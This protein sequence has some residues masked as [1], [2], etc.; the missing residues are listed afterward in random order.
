MRR[1]RVEMLEESLENV[2]VL[3][4][5]K[6]LKTKKEKALYLFMEGTDDFSYYSNKISLIASVAD[7]DLVKIDCGGKSGVVEACKIIS[8]GKEYSNYR[9]FY[10]VDKDYNE[11]NLKD[12]IYVTPYYSMDS[13]Y[14]FDSV[15]NKIL[16]DDM[17]IDKQYVK[18]IIT[19]YGN[20]KKELLDMISKYEIYFIKHCAENEV[21]RRERRDLNSLINLDFS[22]SSLNLESKN[23]DDEI[24]KLKATVRTSINENELKIHMMNETEIYSKYLYKFLMIFLKNLKKL[25]LKCSSRQLS[26]KDGYKIYAKYAILPDCLKLYS[27]KILK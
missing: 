8:D 18:K 11:T 14:I 23:I 26:D 7:E 27:E 1:E 9:C 4:V 21:G 20:K 12:D 3:G 22:D 24:K 19:I 17:N 6:F 2:N 5:L 25:N 15:L 13:F 10:F 16:S